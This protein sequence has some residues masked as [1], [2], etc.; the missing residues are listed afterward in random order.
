M[1]T[2]TLMDLNGDGKPDLVYAE[3]GSIKVIIA[4]F[5]EK[6]LWLQVRINLGDRFSS[7]A[8]VWYSGD[9]LVLRE[10]VSFDIFDIRVKLRL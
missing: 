1:S 5:E 2:K 10:D 4:A 8:L 3:S 7:E 6:Y 9:K